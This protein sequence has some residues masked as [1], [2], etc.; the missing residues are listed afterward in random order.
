MLSALILSRNGPES[1]AVTLSALVAGVAQG[2]VADAVVIVEKHD[3]D[4]ASIADATGAEYVVAH[5]G[6]DPWSTGARVARREWLI[7]LEAGDLPL[8]GWIDAVDRF[9]FVASMEGFP[10]GRL[11]RR[12]RGLREWFANALARWSRGTRAGDVVHV[13]RLDGG[14]SRVAPIPA[15]IARS[16]L[17]TA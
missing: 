7:C 11:A 16:S 17:A 15:A 12:S 8:E 10:V 13:S 5:D 9:A 6:A 1:L 14:R 2:V 4:S 3:P